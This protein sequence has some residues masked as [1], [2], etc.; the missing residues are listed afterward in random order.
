MVASSTWTRCK[1]AANQECP[2][3][4]ADL[5]ISP[6][7]AWASPK[8]RSK[9]AERK[10]WK[11]PDGQVGAD[12]HR[13]LWL[14][15][16]PFSYVGLSCMWPPPAAAVTC[17]SNRTQRAVQPAILLVHLYLS[18][19]HSAS[20]PPTN[21]LQGNLSKE[22]LLLHYSRP[23]PFWITVGINPMQHRL[24]HNQL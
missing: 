22:W 17:T 13:L 12:H 16:N 8:G 3:A 21:L 9:S 23:L 20:S 18:N 5:P 7:A 11:S 14:G 15:M 19:P 24:S 6:F 2:V 4:P 10:L 1:L